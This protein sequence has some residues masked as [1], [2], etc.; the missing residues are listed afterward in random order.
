MTTRILTIVNLICLTAAAYLGVSLFYK[1][2]DRHL[3]T[4]PVVSAAVVPQA[5]ETRVRPKAENHYRLVLDRNLFKTKAV[6]APMPEK[7]TELN[8]ETLEQ[9]K[10]KLKLWG[11]VAPSSDAAQ[12]KDADLKAKF[13]PVAKALADNEDK[14]NEELLA[15]QGKAENYNGYYLPQDDLAAVAMRPSATLNK[16]I[17]SI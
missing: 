13:G 16:I 1:A 14:I 5:K 7:K 10:L 8:L 17:D 2:L 4:T 6:A 12:D 11:T 9:T 3:A 15:A